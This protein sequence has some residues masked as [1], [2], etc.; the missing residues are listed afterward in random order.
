MRFGVLFAQPANCAPGPKAIET[1]RT[2]NIG[3]IVKGAVTRKYAIWSKYAG[4]QP[5][6]GEF[7]GEEV[8]GVAE[9]SGV[10]ILDDVGEIGSHSLDE[11]GFHLHPLHSFLRPAQ[12]L[13]RRINANNMCPTSLA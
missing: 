2:L 10:C 13:C 11:F 3:A 12:S 9:E 4:D 8:N 6:C 5:E 1:F 7:I